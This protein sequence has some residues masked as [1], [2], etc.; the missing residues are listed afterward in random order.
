MKTSRYKIGLVLVPSLLAMSMA[1]DTGVPTATPPPSVDVPGESQAYDRLLERYLIS[2]FS[3][4]PELYPNEL[5][6]DIPLSIPVP[7]G[8]QLLGTAV[9][10]MTRD[11]RDIH[12]FVES[13]LS[14]EEA[15]AFYIEQFAEVG[16]EEPDATIFF[17][18]TDQGFVEAGTPITKVFCP[19]V[20][21]R[22]TAIKPITMIVGDST[23]SSATD[24]HVIFLRS[25]RGSGCE[26]ID[27]FLRDTGFQFP[28]LEAP[29]G[30]NAT[31]GSGSRGDSDSTRTTI[32][33]DLSMVETEEHYRE[34]LSALGWE[35]LKVGESVGTAW[36]TWF[37]TEEGFL[38]P[39]NWVG[40]LE[41]RLAN[42][43]PPYP[44]DDEDKKDFITF[45]VSLQVVTSS[46]EER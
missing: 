36:S 33:T 37:V 45:S 44:G 1:C 41:V 31:G 18:I 10:N 28:R 4:L 32:E 21:E 14:P 29:Q 46:E 39:R 11:R 12:V 43:P 17:G 5:P 35:L 22:D 15:V 27:P 26:L 40:M 20:S 6:E 25:D 30:A 24:I 16:G 34:Q 2:R 3:Q 7:E 13:S 19:P 8:G 23:S 38:G 42:A 9:Q